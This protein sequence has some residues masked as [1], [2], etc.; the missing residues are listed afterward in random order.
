MSTK[1]KGPKYFLN[2]KV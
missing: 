1:V 2:R